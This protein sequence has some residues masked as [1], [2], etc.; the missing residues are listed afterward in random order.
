MKLK[1][2]TTLTPAVPQCHLY[3]R[4]YTL[5]WSVKLYSDP[6]AEVAFAGKVHHVLEVLLV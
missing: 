1:T 3:T 6:A 5:V 4:K 2:S